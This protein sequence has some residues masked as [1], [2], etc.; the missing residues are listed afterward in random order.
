LFP[1][2]F[3]CCLLL[4]CCCVVNC[5]LLRCWLH[6]C[7]LRSILLTRYLHYLVTLHTFTRCLRSAVV[8]LFCFFR[9]LRLLHT[10]LCSVFYRRFRLHPF[11]PILRYY[12]AFACVCGLR[13]ALR[14]VTLYFTPHTPTLDWSRW[15]LPVTLRCDLRLF[16]LRCCVD[17]V[18][19]TCVRYPIR[20]VCAFTTVP[21]WF[22]TF[23]SV[24]P[25]PDCA[26]L[27]RLDSATTVTFGCRSRALRYR[28][29]MPP[30][31]SSSPFTLRFD[32]YQLHAFHAFGCCGCRYRSTLLVGYAFARLFYYFAF[33]TRV[34][35]ATFVRC[36][37]RS[38]VV[39]FV[40]LVVYLLLLLMFVVIV[41][42]CCCCCCDT[43][44]CCCCYIIVVVMMLL[45]WYDDLIY[46]CHW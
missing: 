19:F 11:I 29:R 34:V 41:N 33:V 46:L 38:Y 23:R 32:Y 6:C 30:R 26:D 3:C 28:I 24:A 2:T 43:F 15:S 39:P 37:C 22:T 27:V 20:R 40:S 44:I 7:L 14:C 16:V 10:F 12:Y 42:Y 21:F 45:F 17:L 9:L 5:Y 36:V 18:T 25:R 4:Y 8:T 31:P 13:L 1:V 35:R